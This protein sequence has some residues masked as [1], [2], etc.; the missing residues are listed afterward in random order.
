MVWNIWKLKLKFIQLLM[1]SQM[2]M[3]VLELF[4]AILHTINSAEWLKNEKMFQ[5]S[6]FFIIRVRNS[7][8]AS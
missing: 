8:D 4:N 1:S 2:C 5:Y 3:C 7:F 6:F